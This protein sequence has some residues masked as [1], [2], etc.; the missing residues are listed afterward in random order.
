MVAVTEK[1]PD[2]AFQCPDDGTILE[3]IKGVDGNPIGRV[4]LDL[5]RYLIRDAG[6]A[7]RAAVNFAIG[8]GGWE[9]PFIPVDFDY[10]FPGCV[11]KRS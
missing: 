5:Q 3:H 1:Y 6:D 4:H 2:A 10:F 7:Q 9:N 8:Y 11:V